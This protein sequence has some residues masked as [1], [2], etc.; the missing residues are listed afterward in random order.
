MLKVVLNW[1][2]L[3]R[4]ISPT[5]SKPSAFCFN[6]ILVSYRWTSAIMFINNNTT[7]STP[8]HH[9]SWKCVN[10]QSMLNFIGIDVVEAHCY[11][12]DIGRTDHEQIRSRINNNW[13]RTFQPHRPLSTAYKTG[14]LIFALQKGSIL[15]VMTIWINWLCQTKTMCNFLLWNTVGANEAL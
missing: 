15:Q 14:I 3:E 13:C 9:Y 11:V 2:V 7:N 12:V 6:L 5:F 1:R 8:L 10:D 4:N